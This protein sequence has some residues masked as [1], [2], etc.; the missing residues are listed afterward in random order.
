MSGLAFAA[1]TTLLLA[2]PAVARQD[3]PTGPVTIEPVVVN[4]SGCPP[5]TTRIA[6]APGNTS[7]TVSYREFTARI[8]GDSLPYDRRKLCQLNLD[9]HIPD[10]YTYGLRRADHLGSAALTAGTTGTLRGTYYF[11]GV[12]T[13]PETVHAFRGP[14]DGGWTAGADVGQ[15]AYKPC[16]LKGNLNLKAETRLATS[17]PADVSTLTLDS[18]TYHFA[19]R[20]C[21][22]R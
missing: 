18:S 10:G 20:T 12:P 7:F 8:G 17:A 6:V 13:P 14:L 2:P 15:I 19:W 21:P 16:G 22:R 11:A 5:G 3:P 9:V 4:G 1:L